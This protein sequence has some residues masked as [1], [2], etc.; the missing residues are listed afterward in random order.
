MDSA[1]SL[2]LFDVF[3]IANPDHVVPARPSRPG[4]LDEGFDIPGIA[5]SCRYRHVARASTTAE[6]KAQLEILRVSGECLLGQ[7]DPTSARS[8]PRP[9]FA[10]AAD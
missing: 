5:R 4:A 8:G 7:C 1:G 9:G 3:L 2:G 10:I 6:I